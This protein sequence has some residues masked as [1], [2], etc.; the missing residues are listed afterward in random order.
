MRNNKKIYIFFEIRFEYIFTKHNKEML[1][2]A[3][4]IFLTYEN[5]RIY[6]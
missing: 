5:F 3:L 1:L 6:F 4:E 2:T